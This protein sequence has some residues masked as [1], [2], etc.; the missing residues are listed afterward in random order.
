MDP[1]HADSGEKGGL[2]KFFAALQMTLGNPAS[3]LILKSMMKVEPDGRTYLD[4]ALAAYAGA[5]T[6]PM[7]L[8][9][10]FQ[11]FML[12][13]IL[14]MGIAI[15][16]ADDAGVREMLRDPPV[17]RGIELVLKGIADYGI[18]VPQEMPA[19]FLV[20][21]NFTNMCNLRCKH[22]YQ[23]ADFP[24]PDELTLEEKLKVVAQLDRA[25]LAAVAFS[26][27]EPLIH[28]HFMRVAGE[29]AR[30]G[31]YVAVATNGIALSNRGFV[32]RI[33]KIGVRYVEVSI[34]SA[35]PDRHDWFRRMKGAWKLSTKGLRNA[36]ELGLSTA[37]ATTLTRMNVDEMDDILD[38]AEEIGVQRVIFFNFVPVGRGKDIVDMDLDP[39]E[40]ERA[41]RKMFSE[42]KRRKLMVVS[43]APYYG[44][45]SLQMSSGKEVAPTHFY[46]GGDSGLTALADFVGG[47]GAGRI[48]AG[49]QPNGDLIPCVF[50]PIK[51][52]NLR[53]EAFWDIWTKAPLLRQLRDRGQLEG[54]CGQC[55]YK[56]VCGGCRARAYGYTGNVM[57]PDPGC[58]YNTKVW[59]GIAEEMGIG[60]DA[61]QRLAEEL[62][63]LLA[64][65]PQVESGAS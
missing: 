47:C 42:Y 59:R 30:R 35:D 1:E 61:R 29:A 14:K 2:T 3:R 23:R 41:M 64:R 57:G 31:M 27:G 33:K 65:A 49:I 7:S 22:C 39:A 13:L 18:T 54:F 63:E 37:M 28:P 16:H 48:Y 32:E 38:L 44:R 45:V 25:G 58:I 36:V 11:S 15:T 26:G 17:R 52:G 43:T 24:L 6:G 51:V 21:W 34:D 10:S 8:S 50:L 62:R 19:P 46:V 56:Y 53:E 12:D 60:A 55:P 9:C 20:V 40:R 4:K 5:D